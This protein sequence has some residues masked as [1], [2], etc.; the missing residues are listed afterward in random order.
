MT[1]PATTIVIGFD[2]GH[3]ETALASA[4]A[5]RTAPPEMLDLPG[6]R[7]RRHISAVLDHPTLGVLVGES[8]ITAREGSPYLGFK[9]PDLGSPEVATPLRLFV[10]RIVADVLDTTPPRP[11]QELRW[12]FGTPSGWPPETRRRYAKILSE[13]CPGHVEVVSESRAALLY[14]RDSGEVSG[15]AHRVTGSVLIVDNGASTQDYTYVSEHSGRPVDHGNIRLGAALIDKEI[16]RRLVLRSPQRPLLEK[17]LAISPAQSRYLELLCRRAKE[18][19]FRTDQQQL[20]VNP[21]NR[22]G[23]METIEAV[24]GEEIMVDIRLSYA[25]MQEVL[26]SPR[27]ELGGLTWRDA[28][29][30]DLATVLG[31]LP[32]PAGLVLLTGGPSRMAFVREICRELVADPD[33][34]ALGGEPEF[35]IARG[36]ALAGRTSVRTAGFRAAVEELLHSGVVEEIA[37]EHLPELAAALGTAVAGGVTERHVIGAFK[38]WR[39]REFVTLQDMAERVAADIAEELRDPA[40]PRLKQVIADW[41]NAIAP[42]LEQLTRPLAERWRLP[43]HA[44]ELPEVSVTGA[45]EFDVQVDLGAATGIVENVA[46]VMNVAVATVVATVLFGAGTAL[47]ATTG[48]FAV[49]VTFGAVWWGVKL[50]RD[51]MMRRM[52]TADFPMWVRHARSE[53]SLAAKLRGKSAEAETELAQKMADQFLTDTGD[54]LVRDVSAAIAAQLRALADEAALEIS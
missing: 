47:I 50:G 43:A 33:R 14:A 35:A 20:A 49:L 15:S 39:E 28:F 22:I 6:S 38:R 21:K 44:L 52:R 10:T 54:T 37:R 18:E 7:A 30:K 16:Y 11:G 48:P 29:R 8:A 25:D 41:Q 31:N 32:A 17:T 13:L 4:H 46:R 2:L 1:D 23:V 36:L 12:V 34:V 45:G 5:D 19:Y 42:E 24:D 53:A 51:E 9:S 40:N 3:G 26:D 27:P